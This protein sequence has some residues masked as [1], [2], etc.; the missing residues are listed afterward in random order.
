MPSVNAQNPFREVNVPH[1]GR[2]EVND[3][4][5]IKIR[6]ASDA[7]EILDLIPIGREH[8]SREAVMA[9]VTALFQLQKSNQ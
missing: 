6:G 5:L 8:M 1:V 2:T 9:A 4:L 3:E 7:Q